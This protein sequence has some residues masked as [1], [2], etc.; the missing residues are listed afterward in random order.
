[1][2]V[3]QTRPSLIERYRQHLLAGADRLEAAA[4]DQRDERP[5]VPAGPLEQVARQPRQHARAGAGEHELPLSGLQQSLPV[6]PALIRGDLEHHRA[7]DVVEGPLGKG[8]TMSLRKFHAGIKSQ[9]FVL[10]IVFGGLLG[11]GPSAAA[12]FTP[13]EVDLITLQKMEA[14]QYTPYVMAMANQATLTALDALPVIMNGVQTTFITRAEADQFLYTLE[15]HPV[16][17]PKML[18]VYDP[19]GAAGFC[20]GRAMSVH[21]DAENRGLSPGSIVKLWVVGGMSGWAYHTATA[22]RGVEQTPA[23]P[24]QVFVLLRQTAVRVTQL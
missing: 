15:T 11:H 12:Q 6:L 20:W 10:A 4:G 3:M 1:M 23:G 22:L 14:Q 5:D 21:A 24:R 18:S 8:V 17:S 2:T 13:A 19:D 16:A 7:A 9:L